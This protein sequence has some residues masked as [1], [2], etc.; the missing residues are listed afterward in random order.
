M[1]NPKLHEITFSISPPDTLPRSLNRLP[2][3]ECG[4]SIFMG[5]RNRL[6]RGSS[7]RAD[8]AHGRA[9]TLTT[10]ESFVA[11]ELTAKN[12]DHSPSFAMPSGKT[13]A[14]KHN[15]CLYRTFWRCRSD[16]PDDPVASRC[17]N[18]CVRSVSEETRSR[19]MQALRLHAS[20]SSSRFSNSLDFPNFGPT[21][22]YVS[23]ACAWVASVV[24]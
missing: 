11:P 16:A 4:Q 12:G 7:S 19:L 6:A 14:H 2:Q 15:V 13:T 9:R 18:R 1:L 10:S 21:R 17:R 22:L 3:V 23:V 20:S 5:P 8:P 24:S